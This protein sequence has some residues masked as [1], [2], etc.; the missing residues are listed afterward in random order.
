MKKNSEPKQDLKAKIEKQKKKKL[1]M[2]ED[3]KTVYKNEIR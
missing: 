3:K 1:K 2:L